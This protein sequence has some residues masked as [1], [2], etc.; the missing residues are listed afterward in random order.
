MNYKNYLSIKYQQTLTF[1]CK[2]FRCLFSNSTEEYKSS[3]VALATSKLNLS[4]AA[5]NLQSNSSCE[6]TGYLWS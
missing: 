5:A 4:A 1:S 3:Y 2:S 6:K